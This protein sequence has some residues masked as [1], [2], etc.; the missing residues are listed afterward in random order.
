MIPKH[1]SGPKVFA[2]PIPSSETERRGRN[3]GPPVGF[4]PLARLP[5]RDLSL[6]WKK[7]W[8]RLAERAHTH[9]LA[10]A[11]LHCVDCCGWQ[12]TEAVRCEVRQCALW[13][14]N[15]RI[16]GAGARRKQGKLI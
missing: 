16:F 4:E 9:P 5:K 15:R 14:L 8:Q 11:E 12:R 3:S 1:S 7:Y 2:H 6:R 10:A 13:A